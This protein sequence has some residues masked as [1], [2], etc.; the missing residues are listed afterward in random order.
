MLPGAFTWNAGAY[1]T[2]VDRD[3]LLLATAINGFGFFQ[4]AG[5]TRHQGVDLSLD[6]RDE[7]WKLGASYSY[8][9]ATFQNREAL[10]S[11]SPAAGSDGLILSGRATACR[12]IRQTG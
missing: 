3:I 1:R 8:L 7:R 10:S 5:L 11:N 6:Y 2:N 4:N 12:P 9:D